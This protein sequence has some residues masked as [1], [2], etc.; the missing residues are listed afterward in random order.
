MVRVLSN[1]NKFVPQINWLIFKLDTYYTATSLRN[2][3]H[4]VLACDLHRSQHFAMQLKQ[5][6]FNP[7]THWGW[8]LSAPL[9]GRPIAQKVFQLKKIQK[10]TF[11]RKSSQFLPLS[12]AAFRLFHD[13]MS[14]FQNP[15]K[16]IGLEPENTDIIAVRDIAKTLPM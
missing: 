10:K 14:C 13:S 6:T 11:R 5:L 16:A 15:C 2:F 4:A 1:R 9:F 3:L 7:L 8:G 12:T